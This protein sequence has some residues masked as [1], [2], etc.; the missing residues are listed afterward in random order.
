MT[1]KMVLL[2]VAIMT[3]VL[4]LVILWQ[5]RT[6]VVYLL[7]SLA[8]AAAVRPVVK[9]W[10]RQGFVARLTLIFLF[11]L[12]LGSFGFLFVLVGGSA[13][14]DINQLAKTVAVQDEWMLPEWMGNS[15]R[16][17]LME[18]LPSPSELFAAFTGDQ[19][20]LVLP[21]ILGVTR[22]IAG[23][24]SGVLVILF[25][26]FYWSLNQ[27]HFERLWLS[28]LPPG[29]R[30]RARNIWQTIEADLGVYIRSQVVQSLLAGLLLGLGYWALG[31]PYPTL[32]ALVGALASLIPMVGVG[33]AV[34]LPLFIGLLTSV[35]LGLLTALY[36]LVVLIALEVWVKPRLFNHR[37]YNP[38][39][40]VVILIAMAKTFGFVGI[41]AAPPLSAA[42]Q[43]LWRHLV[44]HRIVLGTASQL[45]D[46]QERYTLLLATV[47]AMN[48]PP[49]PLVTSSM[50]RL[51]HLMDKAGPILQEAL[52]VELQNSTHFNLPQPV[53]TKIPRRADVP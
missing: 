25:L 3:T 36:T 44:V 17:P 15:I 31:S 48:E 19:G 28:L 9:R 4:A 30:T 42:I 24:V 21:A 34:I 51:T 10:S 16:M 8:L 23:L 6:P 18:R 49:S 1:R 20:Q 33:L 32:L 37:Q 7:V 11:V 27:V 43:I 2:G 12:S 39:L 13:L 5:F 45:S 41:I 38:I 50:E 47:Q 52:P 46:L 22:G 29:H 40:T 26:S 53:E 35:Q 14:S